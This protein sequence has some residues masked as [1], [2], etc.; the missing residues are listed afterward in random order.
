[1]RNI[2]IIKVGALG[3][4]V[5]T[6]A[7]LNKFKSD[8][9]TWFTSEKA[10]P[11]LYNNPYIGKV[12]TEVSINEAYESKYD[13]VINMDE[14]A[15][16]C[17]LASEL[18]QKNLAKEIYGFYMNNNSVDYKGKDTSWL[19][20]SLS[21]K[22]TMESSSDTRWKNKADELK[23]S[24]RRSYEDHMFS[25]LGF[26]FNGEEYVL[27]CNVKTMK[28]LVGMQNPMNRETKWPMKRW[29]NYEKLADELKK[30]GYKIRLLDIQ[31]D[32]QDH[33]KDIAECEYIICEDS[34]PMQ[35]AIALKKQT[36]ALFICTSPYEIYGYGRVTKIIS[37]K[38]KEYFYRRDFDP[39]AAN[40]I[41]LNTVLNAFKDMAEKK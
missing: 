32:L 13:I 23:W 36:I 24:N 11:L 29:N 6:T 4:V 17:N 9:V 25:I 35:I 28:G 40:T 34:L 22:L 18:V 5:R 39:D 27:D 41:P 10:K 21:G 20:I 3:D 26:K 12:I 38:L 15:S 14:E 33:I 8:N 1:M 19:D 30:I 2:L 37:P 16:C 7:I 31:E